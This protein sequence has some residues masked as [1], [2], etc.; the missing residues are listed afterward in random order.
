MMELNDKQVDLVE[1]R[2][3][4][5]GITLYDLRQSLLDHVCCLI[6]EKLEYGKAFSDAFEEAFSAFGDYGLQRIQNETEELLNQKQNPMKQLTF[7]SGIIAGAL[8]T[9]GGL[10]KIFH[11]PGANIMTFSGI[12]GLVFIF[13]PSIFVAKFKTEF[14]LAGKVSQLAGLISLS[15]FILGGIFRFLHWPFADALIYGG[16]AGAILIYLPLLMYKNSLE[17]STADR[18]RYV[19]VTFTLS[20]A[21]IIFMSLRT[22]S[23]IYVGGY[24]STNDAIEEM[25]AKTDAWRSKADE[26][27]LSKELLDLSDA[28][29]QNIHELKTELLRREFGAEQNLKS[30]KIHESK[31]LLSFQPVNFMVA[32]EPAAL[33]NLYQNLK[34]LNILEGVSQ[35]EFISTYFT[36]KSLITAYT[37]LNALELQVKQGLMMH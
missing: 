7:I 34:A 10:F 35:D 3:E 2:L 1:Q 29:V 19:L 30:I 16:A 13:L 4:N 12:L 32:D 26:S 27:T 15:I 20:M 25:I 9:I 33:K 37:N 5:L 21:M 6:E 8:I 23:Q 22:P 24:T 11:W 31:N 18:N 28:S 17:K 14:S 36:N